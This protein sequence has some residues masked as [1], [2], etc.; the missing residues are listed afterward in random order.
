MSDQLDPSLVAGG[1]SSASVN[2]DDLNPNLVTT[3]L[4]ATLGEKA[5]AVGEGVAGGALR[6]VGVIPGVLTGATLGAPAGPVGAVVGGLVGGGIGMWAGDTAAEGLRLR[7]P[8]QMRQEVRKY[9]V[10]GESF[11]GSMGALGFPYFAAATGFRLGQSAAGKLLNRIID[12]AKASPWKFGLTEASMASSAAT[13]AMTAEALFPGNVGAR[14]GAEMVG[15]LV[16]PDRKST[17]LNSSH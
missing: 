10:L 6:T 12:S 2:E 3:S 9:G 1:Q 17:R 15:G 8:E 7:Q 16:N 4:S 5:S 14:M 13:A 11:G